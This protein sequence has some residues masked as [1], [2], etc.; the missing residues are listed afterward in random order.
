MDDGETSAEV[1]ENNET[2]VPVVVSTIK[3]LVVGFCEVE[4]AAAADVKTEGTVG[5]Q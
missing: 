1:D 5:C 3:A 2:E 4:L